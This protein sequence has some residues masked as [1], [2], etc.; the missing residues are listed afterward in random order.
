M[1]DICAFSFLIVFRYMLSYGFLLLFRYLDLVRTSGYQFGE[2]AGIV[3]YG[4]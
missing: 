3:D 4:S 2:H 1:H